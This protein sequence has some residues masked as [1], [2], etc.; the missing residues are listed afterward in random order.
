MVHTPTQS[1][2]GREVDREDADARDVREQ[3]QPRERGEDR[4]NLIASGSRAAT[5][6][7][8]TMIIGSR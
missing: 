7:P 4:E 3:I 8:N 2:P 1:Q 5:R 6:L